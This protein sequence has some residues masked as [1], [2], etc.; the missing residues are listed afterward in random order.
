MT[1]QKTVTYPS[2]YKFTGKITSITGLGY[3]TQGQIFE[4]YFFLNAAKSAFITP[5]YLIGDTG[6]L[7]PLYKQ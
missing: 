5:Y 2:G 6:E 4:S 7:L 1:G 3:F